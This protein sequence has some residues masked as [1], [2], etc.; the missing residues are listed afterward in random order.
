MTHRQEPKQILKARTGWQQAETFC[1]FSA[2]YVA[3][4]PPYRHMST[5]PLHESL[6]QSSKTCHRG[7]LYLHQRPALRTRTILLCVCAR[8]RPQNVADDVLDS[9]ICGLEAAQVPSF[10]RSYSWI[11][12]LRLRFYSFSFSFAQLSTSTR[13]L[14]LGKSLDHVIKV[15][16]TFFLLFGDRRS[17]FQCTNAKLR[18]GR[19]QNVLYCTCTGNF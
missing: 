6:T 2:C 17:P 10:G 8:V 18:H 5:A 3:C 15:T 12:G 19:I 1:T 7:M 9:C 16:R 4:T 11:L 13:P 14:M